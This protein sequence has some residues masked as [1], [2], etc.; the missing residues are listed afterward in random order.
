MVGT[1]LALPV[2]GRPVTCD[3]VALLAATAGWSLLLPPRDLLGRLRIAGDRD[4]L[5]AWLLD[6]ADDVDAAV[7][8]LDMLVY[9]G[10]VPS[11]LSDEPEE[12]LAG[13][14]DALLRLR[15]QRPQIPVVVFAATMRIS[16]N[17]HAEEERSYWARHG[18]DI[19]RWSYHLD[20]H[21]MLGDPND[22]IIAAGL[23]NTIPQAVLTDYQAVR[24]RNFAIAC[25][26]L[27]MVAHGVIDFLVLPQDDT[28][29]F[30]INVGERRSLV[31]MAE[32]LEI[33]DRV[34]S[35]PG[36][37]EVIWTQV[38]RLIARAEGIQPVFALDWSEPTAPAAM[39][40]RYEDRPVGETVAA[41]IKAA[42]GRVVDAQED[43]SALLFVHTAGHE[44]G[45]WALDIWP[46]EAR[47][48]VSADW[49]DR[50][51]SRMSGGT[52]VALLDLA[53]A[54]G[55]DPLMIAS[56]G[57]RVPLG[58]LHA[59]AGW[60]T[61]GNSIGSAVALCTVPRRDA[62]AH[63]LLLATR[64]VDD[65]VYQAICRQE[66]RTAGIDVGSRSGAERAVEEVFRPQAD[67][68]LSEHGFSDLA[69][70]D[71]WFPW[72]RTFEIAFTMKPTAIGA[73]A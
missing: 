29:P 1:I 15:E 42:G 31:E 35:Y 57:E 26:A 54:N 50:A 61:A 2:D 17:D 51:A 25:R 48:R 3:Q 71:A 40:A 30:G 53:D 32:R 62:K 4:Q 8:S 34:A 9:G 20:R 11:R 23:A 41:Q 46:E 24:G 36:A 58:T 13:R 64:F 28:A 69:V 52:R 18:R 63:R 14:L 66:I 45:E 60:N 12:A 68:W 55:G 44:Q 43:A 70:A 7:L 59:Y 21:A 65:L 39:V 67:A 33:A 56:L 49:L 72:G 5:A 47:R 37:D 6:A 22:E 73:S 19:W 10:L 38:A 16:S 27:E